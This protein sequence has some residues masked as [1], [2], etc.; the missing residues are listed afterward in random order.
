MSSAC[1]SFSLWADLFHFLIVLCLNAI[2]TC[3][4]ILRS[5]PEF[6]CG[7]TLYRDVLLLFPGQEDST[8]IH[9]LIYITHECTHEYPVLHYLLRPITKPS[10]AINNTIDWI[11]KL[12]GLRLKL[13]WLCEEGKKTTMEKRRKFIKVSTFLWG[14]NHFQLLGRWLCLVQFSS[15]YCI[16]EIV[17]L[18]SVGGIK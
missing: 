9:K 11:L 4:S 14:W 8:L 18:L 7:L 15:L 17:M 6:H 5:E 13:V 1:L 12:K 2:G 10:I 3:N 16:Q